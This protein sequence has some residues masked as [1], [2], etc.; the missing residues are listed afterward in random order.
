M[1]APKARLL[2]C[3]N[4]DCRVGL[5][6]LGDI[7]LICPYCQQPAGWTTDAPIPLLPYQLTPEDVLILTT[8]RIDPA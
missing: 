5:A 1:K 4:P 7:P 8:L 3:L 6:S 2:W